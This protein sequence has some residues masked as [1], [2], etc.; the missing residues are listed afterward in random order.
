MS[1]TSSP[2]GR[3]DSPLRK[4]ASLR[5]VRRAARTLGPAPAADEADAADAAGS[6]GGTS[7]A[8]RGAAS[9]PRIARAARSQSTG[10]AGLAG[11]GAGGR[12][13]TI[14]L[15]ALQTP[16]AGGM[17][18]GAEPS[19]LRCPI[20]GVVAPS[21]FAL[22][23][24]LDDM[25]FASNAD[26]APGTRNAAQDD[27]EE[28]KGAILGFFRGAGRAV[29]GLGAQTGP[30][31]A[32][33]SDAGDDV[34]AGRWARGERDG[35]DRGLV[36]RA[37]WQQPR[38]GA[39]CGEP[40]CGAALAAGA[41]NCRCCGRLMCAQHCAQTLR[42]SAT[43]QAAR[44]G[45]EC[46]VC[47]ECAAR[48]GGAAGQT[49]DHTRGFAHLRRRTVNAAVLEGNRVEKRLERLAAVHARAPG[50]AEPWSRARALQDAEQA[51]VA[52]E[53]DAAV[54]SCPFCARVFGRVATR[55]HHCRLCGRV[56]CGR[57]GC[58]AQLSVPLPRADGSGFSNGLADGSGFSNGRADIRACRECDR[59]VARHRDRIARAAPQA[60]EL[61]RLYAHIR[62]SMAQVE[63]ALPVFNALA[64]RLH[65]AG[66]EPDLPRAARI[67]KQLTAAFSEMDRASKRIAALPA[68]TAGDARVHT[69]VRRT[70]AQYLQLHMFPLTMLPKAPRRPASALSPLRVQ[71][72]FAAGSE[73]ADSPSASL[74]SSISTLNI[75]AAR[76]AP[77][78]KASS[79]SDAGS[80]EDSTANTSNSSPAREAAQGK[81]G[82]AQGALGLPARATGLA[83]SLL[84]YV[85]PSKPRVETEDSQELLITQALHSD[86]G[87]EQRIASM[88]VAE[89]MASLD[90]LRDQ[91]Q[92]VLG[93][94]GEAQKD[95]RLEDAMSLQASL[96]DLD[97][98]LSLIERSL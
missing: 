39:R 67:R 1:H 96:N 66:A 2:L 34:R 21:L 37:H 35:A 50:A 51:V 54:A 92:R 44:R 22:N 26:A 9:P 70:V 65:G 86:P 59:T 61:M 94:I 24:H 93:Y 81:L 43:A 41:D 58:S 42:L 71:T 95:R 77:A 15:D 19:T 4:E 32:A 33:S 12:R 76:P 14:S 90:V 69:A 80:V 91:R 48:A 36:T 3:G 64:M 83:S 29:R 87:K 57:A 25:H 55:R 78:A 45:V 84:S 27:L 18:G 85:V 88:P 97:V 75:D 73:P 62:A 28:V 20:C 16:R 38:A 30:P 17:L 98:E 68:A 53:D 74:P 56:V 63:E 13:S 5:H 11:A 8:G 6:P 23:T 60:T 49:R 31:S 47:G 46:R 82:A 10:E 52:W 72:A 79:I 40:A 89:K 7:M